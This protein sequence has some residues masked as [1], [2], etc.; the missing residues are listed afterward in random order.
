MNRIRYTFKPVTVLAGAKAS[1]PG[2]LIQDR[3]FR[4]KSR[5]WMPG[6][7]RIVWI[8]RRRISVR[9]VPER[10]L[11]AARAEYVDSVFGDIEAW[12]R[13]ANRAADETEIAKFAR[14]IAV[15]NFPDLEADADAR[16]PV[17]PKDVPAETRKCLDW[18]MKLGSV[19]RKDGVF[20]P[21]RPEKALGIAYRTLV[22]KGVVSTRGFSEVWDM[23]L[24]VRGLT[25]K[26]VQPAEGDGI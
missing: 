17:R 13:K 7:N 18:A 10:E 16:W 24:A 25:G 15:Q 9:D 23:E 3:G 5:V 21:Y 1:G 19:S 22:R 11:A 6:L 2:F 14:A 26:F 8:N 12:C 20:R 4:E